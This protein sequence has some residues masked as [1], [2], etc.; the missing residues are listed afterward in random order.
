MRTAA[1]LFALGALVPAS[2]RALPPVL[3]FHGS[4]CDIVFRQP[5]K[6]DDIQDSGHPTDRGELALLDRL[7]ASLMKDAGRLVPAGDRLTLVFTNIQ[8]AGRYE[9]WAGPRWFDVRIVRPEYFPYFDFSYRLT[10]S[11]GRVVQAGR[12]QLRDLDFQLRPDLTEPDPLRYEKDILRE[13]M[14]RRIGPRQ[15]PSGL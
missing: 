8:L 13:W 10:D 9:P 3:A 7:Q 11:A 12:E 6:F 2:I 15:S 14:Q 5:A 1:A 4:N